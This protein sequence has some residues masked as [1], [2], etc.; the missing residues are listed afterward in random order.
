MKKITVNL[1]DQS[2]IRD[3]EDFVERLSRRLEQGERVYCNRSFNKD[4]DILLDELEE[5]LYD[6]AVWAFIAWTRLRK[7]RVETAISFI[8][9][10]KKPD[11]VKGLDPSIKTPGR[12]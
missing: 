2:I 12:K 11:P 1:E 4:L 7:K 10:G 8:E 3:F 9:Q 6:Q 5:E